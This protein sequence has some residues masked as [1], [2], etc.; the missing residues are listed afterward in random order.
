MACPATTISL[1]PALL[2]LGGIASTMGLSF[3]MT[4]ENKPSAL[5]SNPQRQ[6]KLRDEAIRRTQAAAQA[7]AQPA[8]AAARP[9]V[10]TRMKDLPRL[11]EALAAPGRRLTATDSQLV[12]TS[13]DATLSFEHDAQGTI[14]AT[15]VR[16]DA[17]AAKDILRESQARY[18]AAVRKATAERVVTKAPAAGW[19]VAARASARDGSTRITLQKPQAKKAVAIG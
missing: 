5:E 14:V 13:P 15:L 3:L 18:I 7:K 4:R 2:A 11:Q 19:V 16:G 17:E 6:Q 8:Q 10:V 12:L 1:L 9:S